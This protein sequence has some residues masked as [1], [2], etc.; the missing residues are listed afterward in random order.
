LEQ[1]VNLARPTVAATPLSIAQ[2]PA[3]RVCA[4][5]RA[6]VYLFSRFPSK[7]LKYR[8]ET[9]KRLQRV[10]ILNSSCRNSFTYMSVFF[11]VSEPSPKML[12]Q[13]GLFLDEQAAAANRKIVLHI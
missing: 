1:L 7:M 4:Q 3:W 9:A 2:P 6:K 8:R 13:N 11:T 10:G 5:R 12:Q